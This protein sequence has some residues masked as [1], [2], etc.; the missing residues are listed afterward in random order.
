MAPVGASRTGN[1]WE[2]E[3]IAHRLARGGRPIGALS[4]VISGLPS[5]VQKKKVRGDT[6]ATSGHSDSVARLISR[7][8]MFHAHPQRNSGGHSN[9]TALPLGTA[10]LGR[11]PHAVV[12]L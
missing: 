8:G 10:L 3:L 1:T 7:L 12:L 9:S 5:V 2:H 4:L 6:F 11:V